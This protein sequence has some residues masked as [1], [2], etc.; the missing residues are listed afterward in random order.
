M[1]ANLSSSSVV[2]SNKGADVASSVMSDVNAK[3]KA[4]GKKLSADNLKALFAG[5]PEKFTRMGSTDM[6]STKEGAQ[7]KINDDGSFTLGA[8]FGKGDW[9]ITLDDG[10]GDG[11]YEIKNNQLN[12]AGALSGA[13]ESAAE[14]VVNS[15]M[16]NDNVF[17]TKKKKGGGGGL[18]AA[19]GG[20]E[21]WFIQMA[22]AMGEALNQM[23]KDLSTAIDK[24][25]T[26]D[27][28]PPF[29]DSMRI[30]G[31]AQQ[32]SFMSQ[33]FMTALNSVGE[34]IKTTVTAG[35]AAR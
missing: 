1:S 19:M 15:L 28:Q 16:D 7:I 11:N 23:S 5:L 32:L 34:A 17:S 21:S 10:N 27:G 31:L 18:A 8:P 26:K 14:K 6:F 20:G 22:E 4:D 13:E 35:G 3:T 30:Q 2:S 24:V 25:Q 33:A 29:K 9:K 12:S